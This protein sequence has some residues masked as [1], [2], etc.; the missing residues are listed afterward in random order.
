M[1][2]T[3]IG[4]NYGIS[5]NIDTKDVMLNKALEEILPEVTFD[6]YGASTHVPAVMYLKNGDPGHPDESEETKSLEAVHIGGIEVFKD[7]YPSLFELCERQMSN[8]IITYE[9][10]S[11]EDE[12]YGHDED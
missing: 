1:A 12:D 7:D 2:K 9:E 3:L 11:N 8:E 5:L 4:Y 10:Y 6:I